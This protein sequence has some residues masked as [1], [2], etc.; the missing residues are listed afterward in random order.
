MISK[1]PDRL[2]CRKSDREI[3]DL[4]KKEKP[5][6]KKDLIHI[7]MMALSAGY[8]EENRVKLD[9]KEGLILLYHVPREVKSIMKAI[10]V[11]EEGGNLNVLV[12]EGK[13]YSI[14]EEYA[15]GGINILKHKVL[16]EEFGSYIKKLE[17][18]LI[19]KYEKI[20]KSI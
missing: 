9:T 10:A 20:K 16:R 19:D 12:D 5:F 4:L 15:A 17:S 1:A 18:E 3:Y 2:N 8:I 13:V 14:A 7:F 6:K 11:E